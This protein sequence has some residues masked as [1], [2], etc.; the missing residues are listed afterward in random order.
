MTKTSD[1]NPQYLSFI[2]NIVGRL[3]EG[4]KNIGKQQVS[5]N[6]L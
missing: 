4:D 3:I 1:M 2:N 6:F 5:V